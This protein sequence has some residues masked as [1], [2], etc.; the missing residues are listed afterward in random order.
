M[1]LTVHVGCSVNL[2]DKNSDTALHFAARQGS[3]VTTLNIIRAGADINAQNMS[4]YTPLMEA[5]CYN[6]QVHTYVCQAWALIMS[7]CVSS[8]AKSILFDHL[9]P[10]RG[11]F[12]MFTAQTL[13]GVGNKRLVFKFRNRRQPLRCWLPAVTSIVARPRLVRRRCTSR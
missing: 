11:I 9:Q 5:V 4:G 3:D 13:V 8:A 1:T 6:N 10:C 12:S 7:C 2:I